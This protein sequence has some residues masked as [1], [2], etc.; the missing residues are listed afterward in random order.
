MTAC[1]T[2]SC[3]QIGPGIGPGIR[4]VS[5]TDNMNNSPGLG[6][7][8][9]RSRTFVS[10]CNICYVCL[11]TSVIAAIVVLRCLKTGRTRGALREPL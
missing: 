4:L 10:C 5:N 7:G 1:N 8:C 9:V 3:T 11:T 2:W 6:P